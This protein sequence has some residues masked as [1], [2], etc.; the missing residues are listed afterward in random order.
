MFYDAKVV[1][2]G[3]SNLIKEFSRMKSSTW[4]KTTQPRSI[5]KAAIYFTSMYVAKTA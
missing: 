4:P 5:E 3:V 2:L 1:K